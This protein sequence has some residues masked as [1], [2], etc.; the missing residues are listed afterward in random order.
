MSLD[1]NTLAVSLENEIPH[2]HR[3][4]SPAEIIADIL[5]IAAAV[6]IKDWKAAALAFAQLLNDLL[7]QTPQQLA[8]IGGGK[9]NWQNIFDIIGKLLPIILGGLT[10]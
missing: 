5:A 3:T 1:P 2:E 6:K 9:I 4:A 10:A 7:G 8:A